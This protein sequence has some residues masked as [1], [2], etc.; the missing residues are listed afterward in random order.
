MNC[1]SP[2]TA[3]GVQD[4]LKR[5]VAFG[6]G[7]AAEGDRFVSVGDGP[8]GNGQL[9][10]GDGGKL[11]SGIFHVGRVRAAGSSA[12][13]T[14]VMNNGQLLLDGRFDSGG[15][16]TGAS[17]V[18]GTDTGSLGSFSM[19]NG[20][21]VQVVAPQAGRSAVVHVGSSPTFS[22]GTG[23]LVMAAGSSISIDG[24]GDSLFGI[25]RNGGTGSLT[26]NASSI[27]LAANGDARINGSAL[28][29]NGSSFVAG[30]YLGIG[31]N[32]GTGSLLINNSTI[33]ATDVVIGAGGF[34]GGSGATV[35]GNVTNYGIFS[36][37]ASPGT[38]TIQGNY[39]AELDSKLI[40]EVE[41]D[42]NGGFR[43]DKVIFGGTVDFNGLDIE[44]KFLGGTD[45]NAFA[46]TGGFQI[47]T[48]L[49][50]AGGGGLDDAVFASVDFSATGGNGVA[51]NN[52]SFDAATGSN[53]APVPEPGAWAL[54]L[55]GLGVLA[56][57]RRRAARA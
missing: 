23:S 42:G 14:V 16:G 17:L 20:S 49:Q 24:A 30:A 26:M 43:T 29:S 51:L 40:L 44:F 53:L 37:G 22:G 36:P 2:G 57:A 18:V 1:I 8:G 13:G 32:G 38:F 25:G 10:I 35:V 48:F 50:K 55:G 27:T 39:K 19:S 34:L 15:P 7:I 9:T 41:S 31:V 47:D 46:G 3:R 56:W 12:T 11:T 5:K 6:G 28:L 54:M 52:F 4:F 21:T 45:P 33:T